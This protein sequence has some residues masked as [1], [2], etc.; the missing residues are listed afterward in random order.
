MSIIVAGRGYMNAVCEISVVIPV[1]NAEKYIERCVNSVLGQNDVELEV[2]CVDD[3]STDNSLAILREY[4]ENYKNVHVLT[5]K[6]QYAGIA[7]NLGLSIAKGEYIHFLDADDYVIEGAYEKIYKK[8]KLY[9]VDYIKARCQARDT[10]T[11]IIY[12]NNNYDMEQFERDNFERVISLENHDIFLNST[13]APWSGLVRREYINMYDLKFNHLRCVN[14]RSFYSD[15]L[16]HSD[17]LYIADDYLVCHMTNNKESLVGIRLENFECHYKSYQIIKEHLN[18]KPEHLR[19]KIL[20]FELFDIAIWYSKMDEALRI[21]YQNLTKD[22]F[23]NFQWEEVEKAALFRPQMNA[24]YD[25]LGWKPTEV[26][27]FIIDSKRE[28]DTYLWNHSKLVIYGAGK[29]CDAL[30]D[31]WKRMQYDLRGIECIVVTNKDNNPDVIHG[32]PVCEK[33]DVE[34]ERVENVLIATFQNAHYSIYSMLCEEC[35]NIKGIANCVF[36]IVV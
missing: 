2:I 10:Q 11:N 24:I 36:E 32:I 7:R 26:C 21:K 12:Q 30:I 8:A 35:L 14:D 20:G 3:G 4:E 25:T 27:D 1:Y 34:W 17:R 5:Q 9:N 15:V 19:G 16:T 28:L 18:E 23:E 13:P 33:D 31:Y 6:N 29:V 22:F